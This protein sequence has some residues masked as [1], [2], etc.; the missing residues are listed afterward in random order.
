MAEGEPAHD[1][2]MVHP[3]RFSNDLT[4]ERCLAL[5]GETY[6]RGYALPGAAI[7]APNA[8]GPLPIRR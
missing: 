3:S 8:T 7:Q 4:R 2:P 6:A 1:L 5:I